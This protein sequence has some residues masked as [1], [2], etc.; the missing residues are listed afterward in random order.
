MQLKANTYHTAADEELMLFIG[1]GNKQAFNELYNRYHKKLLF[2][3]Y[4]LL[5][6]NQEKAQ[7]LLHDIFVQIIE[8]PTQFDANKRFSTWVYTLAK[9]LCLNDI[10]NTTNRARLL[11][12]AIQQ[13]ETS[14]EPPYS[15]QIDGSLFNQEMQKLYETLSQ[16]E[17]LIFTLRFQQELPIKE[18]AQI[19]QCPEGTVKSGIFYLLKK[20]AQAVPQFNPKQ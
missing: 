12:D 18:I 19:L 9:N 14:Y 4:K 11:D 16:K 2:F 13:T 1:N 6:Y 15:A 10:R 8:K 5:N 7:D 3:M 17:Q 20:I